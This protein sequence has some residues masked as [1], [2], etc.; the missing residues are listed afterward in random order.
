MMTCSER[1][2]LAAEDPLEM[3]KF[4]RYQASERKLRLFG[5]A[6]CRRLWPLLTNEW[7]R[8]AVE[9]A[10]RYADEQAN[11]EDLQLARYGAENVAENLIVSAT[12]AEQEAQASAAFAALS[13][14]ATSERLPDYTS[15]NAASAAYHAATATGA[16][17]AADARSGERAAQACLLRDLFGNPFRVI[18]VAPRWLR[19]QDASVARLAQAAYDNRILPAGTLGNDRLAV[20]ADA[21]EEAGCNDEL[22][23]G[24]LRGGGE[25][26]R[27]CFVVDAL[28]GKN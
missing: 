3:L 24:H 2:W 14:T 15:S 1:E 22:I 6:C 20:L 25:H 23:L 8:R 27:G 5:C 10:E 17:S 16:A 13:V 11:G 21:L 7:S 26:Y 18:A 9:V 12:T 19:W 4:L 28:L